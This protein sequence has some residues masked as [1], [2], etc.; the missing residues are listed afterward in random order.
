[1]VS[2]L[3]WAYFF[4]NPFIA[5]GTSM[6][7]P[8]RVVLATGVL[9]AT[10]AFPGVAQRHHGSR[11]KEIS[12]N[13]RDGFW[14]GFSV[15]AGNES[16][17]FEDTP[18]G[19]SDDITAPT[20][21]LRLGGT[22]SQKWLIGAELFAWMDGDLNDYY[23]ESSNVLSSAMMIAQFYPI[24]NGGLYI[25]GGVGV[26]GNYVRTISP[27]GFVV[28]DDESGLATV[29]GAGLDLRVGRSISITPTLDV[30]HQFF[31][32]ID[33]RERIVSL[34]VGLTFH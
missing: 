16:F 7:L 17:R 34:G 13:Y 6:R 20:F 15:G 23:D 11:L 19:Y 14:L 5:E 3:L 25:K 2:G 26:A 31:N 32:R 27:D 29:F 33:V 28:R 30:H 12:H 18:G 10:I 4:P 1:M 22:P 24:R 8:F 21:S 9:A